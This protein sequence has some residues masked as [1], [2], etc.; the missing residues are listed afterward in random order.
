MLETLRPLWPKAVRWV[1][2]KL[3]ITLA[4]KQVAAVKSACCYTDKSKFQIIDD[5]HPRN[6]KGH[7]THSHIRFRPF[8]AVSK[9]PEHLK[10]TTFPGDNPDDSGQIRWEYAQEL[11]NIPHRLSGGKDRAVGDGVR[12]PFQGKMLPHEALAL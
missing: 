4:D 1:Q 5:F 7:L 2:E 9:T 12:G 6:C 11:K 10:V 8:I 3:S